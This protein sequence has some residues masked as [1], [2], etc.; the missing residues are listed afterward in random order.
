MIYPVEIEL[1]DDMGRF[2]TVCGSVLDDPGDYWTPGD[3]D[4]VIEHAY[5]AEG[6]E[7]TLEPETAERAR[8]R[9]F[10]EVG[11]YY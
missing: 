7:V 3:Q 1:D 9:M 11:I 5:D 2:F 4:A 6:R 10:S 8:E